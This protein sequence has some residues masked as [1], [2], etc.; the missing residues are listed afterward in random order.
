MSLNFGFL[1]SAA[2]FAVLIAIP[3]LAWWR[4]KLNPIAAF[5]TAYVIT[6]PLV[7]RLRTG[8]ASH[9]QPQVWVSET[10]R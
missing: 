3:A 6:R 2:L 10:G 9:T 7:P 8:S 4:G 1:G 5:S